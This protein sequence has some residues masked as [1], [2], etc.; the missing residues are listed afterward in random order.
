[1][2]KDLELAK[3]NNPD[4]KTNPA[5]SLDELYD[6]IDWSVK[7]M[8]WNC[9]KDVQYDSLFTALD[10]TTGYFWYLFD[11]PLEELKNK[12]YFYPSLQY[13]KPIA[14]WIKKYSKTWG[15]YLSSKKSWNLE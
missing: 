5:Q 3:K 4:K 11:Q 7:C 1:M 6:F 12:G 14:N 9:L 10:Q 8:P 2:E 15:K 13:F